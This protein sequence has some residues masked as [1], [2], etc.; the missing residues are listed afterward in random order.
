MLRRPLAI[1]LVLAGG[2]SSGKAAPDGSLP[3]DAASCAGGTYTT[4]F[5]ATEDPLRE[6]G[7]WLDGAADGRDWSDVQSVPGLA[8]GTIVSLGPPYSDATA[9]LAGTWGPT[10]TACATVHTVNQTASVFEEVELRLRTTIAK[11]SITGYEFN[12]RAIADGSQ[13]AQIV[14]WNGAINDFTYVDARTGPGLHD[15]D[16]VCATASGTTLTSSINGAMVVQGTDATFAT[17]APGI[18][19][20]N[21]NGTVQ[22]DRDYGFT[23]FTASAN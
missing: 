2:C 20:Y 21:Q 19:F 3:R 16:M 12:F 9:V 18:G 11:G 22:Q 14:R 15:G 17:G 13:Y 5:S 1:A 23:H 4:A 8:F 7:C 10:Q 6:G